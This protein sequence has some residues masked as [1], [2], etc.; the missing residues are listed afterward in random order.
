MAILFV[1][2]RTL[3][4]KIKV[5]NKH[6]NMRMPCVVLIMQNKLKLRT[7]L[8]P[9]V[10]QNAVVAVGMSDTTAANWYNQCFTK[11]LLSTIT[12]YGMYR[13]DQK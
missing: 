4:Y 11:W 7:E 2:V 6:V 13:F 10:L 5:P 9:A 12:K 3:G 8:W 1:A